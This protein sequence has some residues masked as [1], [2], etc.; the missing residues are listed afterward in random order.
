MRHSVA[1]LAGPGV[2]LT[3]WKEALSD[4]QSASRQGSVQGE[5]TG[6]SPCQ[7]RSQTTKTPTIRRPDP[8]RTL[9]RI[10][11]AGEIADVHKA[12]SGGTY[13]AMRVTTELLHGREIIVG[14]NAVA[15]IMAE[16][17]I[18]GLPTRRVPKDARVSAT[19]PSA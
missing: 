4:N 19:A 11:L 13:G 14:R 2:Y 5:P 10:W 3:A 8:P 15:S 1:S 16:L 18:K 9:R 7:R 6:S 12:A 17:E